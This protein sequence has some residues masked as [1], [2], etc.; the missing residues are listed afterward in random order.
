MLCDKR[1]SARVKEEVYKCCKTSNDDGAETWA[2]KSAQVKKPEVTQMRMLRFMCGVIKN[3]QATNER[4]RGATNVCD[5]SK[6]V[7]GKPVEMV[8]LR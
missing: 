8:W 6:I 2:V 1:I 7:A 4:I 5:I 3:D